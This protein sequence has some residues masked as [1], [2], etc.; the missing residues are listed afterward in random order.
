MA[1][2]PS[3]I[4]FT[5]QY[6]C[7]WSNPYWTNLTYVFHEQERK[8][9]Q[10][11]NNKRSNTSWRVHNVI[12]RDTHLTGIL[13][14]PTFSYIKYAADGALELYILYQSKLSKIHRHYCTQII[15]VRLIFKGHTVHTYCAQKKPTRHQ[16]R[17]NSILLLFLHYVRF[18]YF[19]F[20]MCFCL[21]SLLYD[22]FSHIFPFVIIEVE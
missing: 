19:I 15:S 1:N 11:N 8:D 5:F 3:Y 6:P 16:Q 12:R 9:C 20:K 13:L 10:E 14:R 2:L 7:F 21:I 18:H 22:F 4:I 17:T